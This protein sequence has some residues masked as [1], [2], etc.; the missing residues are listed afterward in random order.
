MNTISNSSTR[1]LLNKVTEWA[2]MTQNNEHGEVL[3]DMAFFFEMEDFVNY[4]FPLMLKEGLT[5]AEWNERYAKTQLMLEAIK[6][7]HGHNIY[8][9]VSKAL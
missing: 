4:F 8:N 9:M 3:C 6:K 1:D 2:E 5:M 7:D